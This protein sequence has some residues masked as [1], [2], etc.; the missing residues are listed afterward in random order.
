MGT[1]IAKQCPGH[2]S[3]IE[4]AKQWTQEGFSD[5][6]VGLDP[7]LVETPETSS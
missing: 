1:Y 3:F 6:K 7:R 5:S 4:V 2:Y